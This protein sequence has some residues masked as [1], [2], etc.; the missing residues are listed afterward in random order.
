[1]KDQPSRLPAYGELKTELWISTSVSLF[2]ALYE[3][4]SLPRTIIRRLEADMEDHRSIWVVLGEDSSDMQG[5][6]ESPGDAGAD[7]RRIIHIVGVEGLSE[8]GY[9]DFIGHLHQLM[10]RMREG[11]PAAVVLWMIPAFQKLFFE[12]Y[13][14]GYR[15]VWGTYDFTESLGAE[16]GTG[17]MIQRKQPDIIPRLKEHTEAIIRQYENWKS[18]RDAGETFLIPAMGE[19]DLR[20]CY[21]PPRLFGND[22]EAIDPDALIQGLL[23]DRTVNF[24][25]LGGGAGVGKTAFALHRYMILARE[26]LENPNADRMPV[27][28][29]LDGVSGRIKSDAFLVRDFEER[30]GVKLSLIQLQD[31]LLR[32]RFIFVIDGF[33]AMG[34]VT[35]L[36]ILKHNFEELAKLSLRNIF[37]EDGVEKP[38][39]ANK[40]LLTCRTDHLI[41]PKDRND[42]TGSV[43]TPL[44]RQYAGRDDH[45]LIRM[46]AGVLDESEIRK[47]V[48]SNTRDGITAR[49]ILGLLADPVNNERLST[50]PLLREM[51]VRTI[52]EFRDK[53]EIN[54]ADFY[55]AYIRL[56]SDADHWRF[57]MTPAGKRETLRRMARLIRKAGEVAFIRGEEL[58]PPV[59]EH[60]K[61]RSEPENGDWLSD[62]DT[63]EFVTRNPEGRYG[64]VHRSFTDYL[65]AEDYCRRIQS[66]GEVED[67]PPLDQVTDE[68]RVFLKLILSARKSDLKGLDLSGIDFEEANLYH[69]DLSGSR[70]NKC[71][72]MRAVLINANLNGVDLS[73]ANL[74]EAKL[75]R[76]T[77]NNA[78]LT[79]ADFSNSRLRDADLR[80]ARFNGA[81]FNGADLRKTRLQKSRLAWVDLRGADLT[82]A[83]LTGANLSDA[84]LTGADLSEAILT[85]ADL[86]GANLSQATLRHAEC[87]NADLTGADLT[88]A[89]LSMANLSWASLAQVSLIKATL[90]RTRFREAEM[91]RAGLREASANQADFRMARLAGARM[92]GASLRESDLSS[93][94]MRQVKLGG[95]DLTWSNLSNAD[96]KEVDFTR[97]KLNMAKLIETDLQDAKMRQA[98]LTWADLSRADLRRADLSGTNLSEADLSHA[99][100]TGARLNEADFKGAN[101][102]KADFRNTDYRN[103]RISEEEMDKAGVQR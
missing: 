69:A 59:G 49:N 41:G 29:S 52:R 2:I 9:L 95:A 94:D 76:V 87:A 89:D 23:E 31:L 79:G 33:D 30:L 37:L 102:Q 63:C 46:G 32:G 5:L 55:G 57:R 48:L 56:W 71:N 22:D 84:D 96:L 16:K 25:T 81:S 47:F 26:F 92:Q 74:I 4:E 66:G 24:M 88:G 86:T 43:H 6:L 100:L 38:Q 85:E 65:C 51:V 11:P 82:G 20:Q 1:M 53:K 60:L 17:G 97:S 34:S 12:A 58:S 18:V 7:F 62:L 75:T 10:H 50:G 3:E 70:L 91:A 42:A 73:G 72:L 21:I 28:I 78:D 35:D 54:A 98:D 15:Q 67:N 99:L 39:Q 101:L 13:P 19:V 80:G 93:T 40:V 36:P 103:A 44:Y 77:L 45:R 61:K 64:F 90:T 14:G 83:D 8:E 68:T 27:F